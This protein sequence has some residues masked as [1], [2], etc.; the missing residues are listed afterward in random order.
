MTSPPVRRRGNRRPQSLVVVLA[1][2]SFLAAVTFLGLFTFEQ[3]VQHVQEIQGSSTQFKYRGLLASKSAAEDQRE[4]YRNHARYALYG[5]E[6]KQKGAFFAKLDSGLFGACDEDGDNCQ[7]G[8][9]AM[10][11]A[12]FGMPGIVFAA[13]LAFIIPMMMCCR[14][15]CRC[16]GG[17]SPSEQKGFPCCCI[18]QPTS[19]HHG[20]SDRD[21]WIHKGLTIFIGVMCF[22]GLVTGYAGNGDVSTGFN[23]FVDALRSAGTKMIDVTVNVLNA[24]KAVNEMVSSI[25]STVT[26]DT[27]GSESNEKFE[28]DMQKMVDGSKEV[29]SHAK[30]VQDYAEQL[31]SVRSALMNAALITSFLISLA[32]VAGAIFHLP[33][34]ATV[35]A[36]MAVPV[37]IVVWM[38]FTIHL[39]MSYLISDVCH[40]ITGQNVVGDNSPLDNI[41]KCSGGGAFG[42][43]LDTAQTSAKMAKK[44]Y[45]HLWDAMAAAQMVDEFPNCETNV[46]EQYAETVGQKPVTCR[47]TDGTN[48]LQGNAL[49]T[50]ET[51]IDK[52]AAGEVEECNATS[53]PAFIGGNPDRSGA[54]A[55]SQAKLCDS[56]RDTGHAIHQV[57]GVITNDIKPLTECKWIRESYNRMED[58][59]CVDLFMGIHNTTVGLALIGTTYFL[60]LWVSLS[61]A[62]R[63]NKLNWKKNKDQEMMM[64]VSGSDFNAINV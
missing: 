6:G 47:V 40:Y 41:L 61:A 10:S 25:A 44:T 18:A 56:L 45:C 7:W 31:N 52:C 4:S 1:A 21:V 20:Y 5:L 51:T 55:M 46:D 26:N 36:S 22:I 37:G 60:G 12:F 13:F 48:I 15:C 58:G 27:S 53:F 23:D 24:L 63:F 11:L 9:Y 17:V 19:E 2:M 57:E 34:A 30:E 42:G 54:G 32:P 33:W 8:N 49:K 59:F 62:K 14:C 38:A 64:P 28:A 43:A 16:W 29:D 39:P 35:M 50:V 3:Q